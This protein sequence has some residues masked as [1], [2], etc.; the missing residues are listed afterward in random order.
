[1]LFE[2]AS[3]ESVAALLAAEQF[4]VNGEIK[5]AYFEIVAPGMSLLRVTNKGRQEPFSR[6]EILR[7]CYQ[8]H[9]PRFIR[10]LVQLFGKYICRKAGEVAESW[11]ALEK[12]LQAVTSVH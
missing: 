6:Q 1:M 12:A 11:E 8:F 9:R 5:R 3:A 7:V 10:P 4:T 2:H